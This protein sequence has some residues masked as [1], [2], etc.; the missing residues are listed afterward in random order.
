MNKEAKYRAI[1]IGAS[2]GGLRAL[3]ALLPAL[4]HDFPCPILIVQH[5]SPK[6]DNYMSRML[7]EASAIHVKEADEKEKLRAGTAYIAPPD[8]HL[9]VEADQTLSLSADDKVNYSRPS[10][11]VLFESAADAFG[12]QLIGI[13][14]TGANADGAEGLLA[15]KR[16]GG[17][18]LVQDPEDAES[19]AMPLA[20]IHLVNPHSI[21]RLDEIIRLLLKPGFIL[22]AI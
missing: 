17:Y 8:Y 16:A 3:K 9:L 13:V 4:P 7:N 22:P 18:T 10:I 14:L 11:D 6:S 1:V 15:V 12:S 21:L 19:K 20:A 5:I 2:A